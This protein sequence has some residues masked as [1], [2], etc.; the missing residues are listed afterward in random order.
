VETEL[1]IGEVA[2]RSGVATSALRFYE[3][4]GLIASTRNDGNHRRYDRT[5]LRRV[6]IIRAAQ[7]V[8]L[9]LAEISESF[10]SLPSGRTPNARDWEK[11]SGSWRAAL[12]DRIARLRGLRDQLSD[13]IGCGCVSLASCGLVNFGDVLGEDGAGAHLLAGNS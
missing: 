8:G 6:A 9:T 11:L 5:I 13:C 3:D 7:S 4:R 12:D 1:T 10:G 2:R